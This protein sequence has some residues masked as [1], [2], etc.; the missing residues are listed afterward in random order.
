MGEAD[1]MLFGGQRR[2]KNNSGKIP[3][4]CELLQIENVL[5]TEFQDH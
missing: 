4:I 2:K 3:G 5:Y 1:M